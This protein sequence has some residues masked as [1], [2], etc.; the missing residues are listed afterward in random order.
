L[1]AGSV[2]RFSIVS[3]VHNVQR[4]LPEFIASI[5]QQTFDLERVEVV[6]V[7]DGSTD[8]SLA[9]LQEWAARRP[10]LVTVLSQPNAGQG[11]ARNA[12]LEHVH[13]EWVTFPDPDD[14]L[15][16]DYLLVVDR[17]LTANERAALVATNRIMFYE[18][19]GV[20]AENHPMRRMMTGDQ[21]VDLDRF[22]GFFHN[23]VA[24]G[25]F[26]REVIEREKLTFDSRIRPIYED[27]YFC[28]RYLL[29]CGAP[30]VGFL[31]SAR[32]TYRK[33][34]D[35]SST[36]QNSLLDPDRYLAVP[37][38]GYLD[39]LHR[40]REG[41]DH[42]PEWLQTM[43]LYDLSWYFSSDA[44][45]AGVPTAAR[46]EV[47]E[48]FVAMLGEIAG[49]LEPAAIK[50]FTL[51]RF[52]PEWRDILLHGFSGS[53]WVSPYVVVDKHDRAQRLVRI[54]YRFTGEPPHEVIY[55]RGL[56]ITPEYAKLRTFDYF[57]HAL[58]YERIAWVPADG[59]LRV[60][61]DGVPTPLRD[62]W[63]APLVLDARPAQLRRL[64]DP[65]AE[66]KARAA[67]AAEELT[68]ADRATVQL[69]RSGPVRR[70][71]RGAWALMDR[72][73]DADDNAERLFRYLRDHRPDINAWFV[74]EQ[75]TPDWER[76]RGDGYGRRL[77]AYGSLQYKL[78]MLNCAHL[79]SSHA[80]AP[81]MRP[82]QILRLAEPGWRFTFL[83]H[84]VIK[85]DIS[86]WLNGKNIDL[87]VTSTPAE[88]ESIVGDGSPY[89]FTSKE[90]KMTGL[91][92]FDRLRELG[93]KVSPAERTYL[94][95]CPT[96]RDWLNEV[97]QQGSHRRTVHDDF[98]QTEYAR[99][100]RAFLCDESLRELAAEEGLRIGFLPHPNIQPALHLFDLP[101]HVEPLEFTGRDVQ[102][103]IAD[104]AL[105]VTD[106]SSMVFNAAYLDRPAVYFQFDADRV[107]GGGHTGRHGYYDYERDGFGPVCSRAEQAV[108]AVRGAVS[109]GR[110][111]PAPE[112]LQ[113]IAAAF[114]ERDGRCCERTVAAVEDLTKSA[115]RK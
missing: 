83:Q 23:S 29:A 89:V 95:V 36:L 72:L 90:V 107:L 35:G 13:G 1:P 59:T 69:A 2:P 5:D 80:D 88:H 68:A 25:F 9:E 96:W 26:R 33:R 11:A 16:P 17:F 112:Y 30:L 60:E 52:R 37:K 56:P 76:L 97:K 103:L 48:Q 101:A 20:V 12:A 39:I 106:Y 19:S 78:L 63:P 102:Q 74:L 98:P 32:Y 3:A 4:F 87:F 71:Y 44:A 73:H 111:A 58:L 31:R 64:A 99:Q 45:V 100:W 42:V 75:G 24:T 93:T 108:A 43:I 104:T 70:K 54:G 38:Y 110:R 15:D 21:L 85:D 82:T 27:G 51:R 57:E 92:R 50:S 77:V 94:L 109:G 14:M 67:A 81:V 62:D 79:L 34:G 40:A 7:D 10:G 49:L 18:K 6:V 86:R 105:M 61:L 91:P 22:P 28:A 41:R 115:P 55:S 84:G 53:R 8:A 114:P 66:T 113:R 47:A 46:G 65:A